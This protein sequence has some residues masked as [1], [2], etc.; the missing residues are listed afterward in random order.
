MEAIMET[1]KW[2]L[3]VVGI[4]LVIFGTVF[5]L[6]GANVIGGSSLMSGNSMYIYVGGVLAVIGVIMLVLGI[7]SKSK[8]ASTSATA[9][10]AR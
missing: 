7:V 6:Q 5:A 2:I 8:I 4:L 1:R 10:T 9:G 3:I